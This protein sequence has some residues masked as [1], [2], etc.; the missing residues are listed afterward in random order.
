FGP[1]SE[2]DTAAGQC[3]L[4]QAGGVVLDRDGRPF[5]YNAKASLLNGDFLALGDPDLP[6]QAWLHD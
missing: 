4:E 6:W 5:V 3:V 2:W 1:T